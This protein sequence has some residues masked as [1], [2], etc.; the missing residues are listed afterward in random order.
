MCGVRRRVVV[1][2]SKQEAEQLDR[3]EA[4]MS[5]RSLALAS[6]LAAV[7]AAAV[8]I[9]LFAPSYAAGQT[10]SSTTRAATGKTSTPPRAADGAPDLQGIWTDSTVTP[11][12]RPKDLGVK[13]FHT[14]HD[15]A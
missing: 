13:G 10:Q 9:A 3:K 1:R 11:F 15:I 14:D 2:S 8:L 5:H 12:E 4:R 6:A 7:V